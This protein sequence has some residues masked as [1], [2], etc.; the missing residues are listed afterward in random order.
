MVTPHHPLLVDSKTSL[1]QSAEKKTPPQRPARSTPVANINLQSVIETQSSVS[2]YDESPPSAAK[3]NQKEAEGTFDT[4]IVRYS[5]PQNARKCVPVLPPPQNTQKLTST[6]TP[7]LQLRIDQIPQ[8]SSIITRTSSDTSSDSPKKSASPHDITFPELALSPRSISFP[9]IELL[10]THRLKKTERFAYLNLEELQ[11]LMERYYS[12]MLLAHKTRSRPAQVEDIKGINPSDMY[13]AKV[14]LSIHL[15]DSP[16][17]SYCRLVFN[18][19]KDLAEGEYHT[20]MKNLLKFITEVLENSLSLEILI[21]KLKSIQGKPEAELLSFILFGNKEDQLSGFIDFLEYWVNIPFTQVEND[22]AGVNAL[23]SHR[24]DPYAEDPRREVEYEYRVV[25]IRRTYFPDDSLSIQPSQIVMGSFAIELD[26]TSDSSKERQKNFLTFLIKQLCEA[27]ISKQLTENELNEC[28]NTLLTI[29]DDGVVRPHPDDP[30]EEKEKL[31]RFAEIRSSLPEPLFSALSGTTV[32]MMQR[33]TLI[34]KA[35][36]HASTYEDNYTSTRGQAYHCQP[37]YNVDDPIFFSPKIGCTH[38][39]LSFIIQS[40]DKT[41]KLAQVDCVWTH[42]YKNPKAFEGY[43]DIQSCRFFDNRSDKKN[44]ITKKEKKEILKFIGLN[45]IQSP[46][47]STQPR[48]KSFFQTLNPSKRNRRSSSTPTS[49]RGPDI[50]P[51]ELVNPSPR[52]STTV[53]STSRSRSPRPLGATQSS[54]SSSLNFSQTDSDDE[55]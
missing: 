55:E 13:V 36:F 31:R 35:I 1:N 19:L 39:P 5:S 53:S 29:C 11:K 44:Y 22:L 4:R 26:N 25:N 38:R 52:C 40:S 21:S 18:K 48:F 49:P 45:H 10:K 3:R 54:S 16:I 20:S 30:P 50:T 23:P 34:F 33:S 24:W 41:R 2:H 6:F 9:D 14:Y 7:S 28:L 15:D 42:F 17:C 32:A 27:K 12:N 8:P 51:R 43:L 47:K 46:N 37:V